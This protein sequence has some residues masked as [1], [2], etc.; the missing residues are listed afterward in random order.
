[1]TSQRMGERRQLYWLLAVVFLL[2]VV[3]LLVG[4]LLKGSAGVTWGDLPYELGLAFVIA[5]VVVFVV[6]RYLKETQHQEIREQ[7]EAHRRESIDA[8]YFQKVLTPEISE[9]VRRTV[10]EQPVIE[11]ERFYRY[12]MLVQDF[13]GEKYLKANITI[14]SILENTTEGQQVT[15]WGDEVRLFKPAGAIED[16]GFK[17]VGVSSSDGSSQFKDAFS[18]IG[19]NISPYLSL[20]RGFQVFEREIRIPSK[21]RLKTVIRQL[22]YHGLDDWETLTA[23]RPTVNMEVEVIVPPGQFSF[24]GGPDHPI[25][26]NWSGS[27]DDDAGHH[28]WQITGGILHSQGIYFA[29]E[30][31]ETS[32]IKGNG[33]N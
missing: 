32:D 22:E 17:E 21:V 12:E 33:M 4:I 8:I 26:A 7:M 30:P 24:S 28:R 20:K 6:E 2:G 31:K 3:L 16:P 23:D 13:E 9:L 27:V 15:K 14:T 5:A 18:L 25:E 1:M 19:P 11:R 10:V 29:W